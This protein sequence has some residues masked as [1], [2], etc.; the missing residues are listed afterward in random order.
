MT[1]FL[2]FFLLILIVEIAICMA[3]KYNMGSSIVIGMKNKIWARQ[4]LPLLTLAMMDISIVINSQ[5]LVFERQSP[6]AREG[7]A[8]GRFLIPCCL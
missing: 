7:R 3:L 5:C 1:A 8:T 6:D 2:L 4:S